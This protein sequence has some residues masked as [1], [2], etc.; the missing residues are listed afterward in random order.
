MASETLKQAKKQHKAA[1]K[2]VFVYCDRRDDIVRQILN[3]ETP[4]WGALN[5]KMVDWMIPR[6]HK[7]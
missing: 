1:L 3:S 5:L 2:N 6:R 4:F 7:I